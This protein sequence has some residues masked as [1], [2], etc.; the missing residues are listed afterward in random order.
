[1]NTLHLA[2]AVEVERCGSITQAAENLYMA[3]PNLSKAIKELEESMGFAIFARTS[4]G[5]VPTSRGKEFL[6]YARA[7]LAQVQ[8]MES[9]SDRCGGVDQPVSLILPPDGYAAA[10]VDRLLRDEAGDLPRA[11]RLREETGPRALE[12]IADGQYSLGLLRIDPQRRQPFSETLR[13]MGLTCRFF[14][15]Y[16]AVILLSARHPLAAADSIAKEALASCPQVENPALSP[17]VGAQ[18]GARIRI[19]G[20]L[21]QLTCLSSMPTAYLISVPEPPELLDRF[22]LVQCS[23]AGIG[24]RRQD[25]LVWPAHSPLSPVGEKL[26]ALLAEAMP[27]AE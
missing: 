20:R 4:R 2:Y 18:E 17:S 14:P 15:A 22:G 13:R 24:I 25:A 1:M 9:L 11:L 26:A 10:C 5:V 19:E 6:G 21:R 23:C 3:Q 12:A 27:Q 8:K 16:D 7:I